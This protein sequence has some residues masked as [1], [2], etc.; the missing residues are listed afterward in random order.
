MTTNNMKREVQLHPE[1]SCVKYFSDHEE[2]QHN[3]NVMI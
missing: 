1:T 2:F 3:I